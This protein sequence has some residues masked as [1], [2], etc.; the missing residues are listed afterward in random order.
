[1]TNRYKVKTKI[2]SVNVD[3]EL[4]ITGSIQRAPAQIIAQNKING[5]NNSQLF[6]KNYY[7]LASD[8]TYKTQFY[9]Q[10]NLEQGKS[11]II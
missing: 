1:M 8:D 11:L 6:H 10:I 9:T 2:K 4:P 7:E 5:D 3:S